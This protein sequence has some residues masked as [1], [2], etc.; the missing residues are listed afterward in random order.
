MS[1]GTIDIDESASDGLKAGVS[2]ECSQTAAVTDCVWEEE[3]RPIEGS[4]CPDVIRDVRNLNMIAKNRR[5]LRFAN[6]A[7]TLNR[8]KLSFAKD[9]DGNPT[10]VCSYPMYDSNRLV[11]EY[12]LLANYLVA[13]HLILHAE[14]RAFLRSHP[15]PHPSKFND[16]LEFA[17]SRGYGE[18]IDGSSAGALAESMRKVAARATKPFEAEV[19]EM[20]AT[21]PMRPAQ[22]FAAGA[23]DQ[24][25]WRHFALNIPYYTHFTSPI[26]R[27][28]DSDRL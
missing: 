22:Y 18:L 9:G 4:T 5:K 27:Y 1:D 23:Q 2:N 28:S 21:A 14:G 8:V 3:R 19:V 11:E 26:R 6:G 15:D 13:Q 24:T 10:G 16:F 17:E 7:L 25:L 12:M 20:L